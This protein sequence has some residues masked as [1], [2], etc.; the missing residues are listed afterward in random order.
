MMKMLNDIKEYLKGF[1][2]NKT[3]LFPKLLQ[4]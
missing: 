2:E 3:F 4:L 1:I